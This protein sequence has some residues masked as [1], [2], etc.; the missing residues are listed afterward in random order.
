MQSKP[1]VLISIFFLALIGPW[2]ELTSANNTLST[3]TELYDGDIEDGYLCYPTCTSGYG[4]QDQYDWYKV[5]LQNGEMLHARLYNNGTPAQVYIDMTIFDSSSTSL[6]TTERVGHQDYGIRTHTATY[7]GYYYIKLEAI[8]GFGADDSYYR[9]YVDIES[10]NVASS[11]DSISLGDQ[12]EEFVCARDCDNHVYNPNVFEDPIDW[13]KVDIPAFTSWG[14]SIDKEDT[15][16]YVDLDVFEVG[17][18]G[19]PHICASNRRGWNL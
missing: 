11:A 6:T 15:Y 16:R 8:S 12:F 14:L 10:N 7:S 1:L 3:A 17:F 4:P 18:G 13:Y 5:Y 2:I 19:F 9:L